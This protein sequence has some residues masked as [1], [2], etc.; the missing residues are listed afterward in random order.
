MT[1]LYLQ[2][3][4]GPD[5]LLLSV[6]VQPE[7]TVRKGFYERKPSILLYLRKWDI[8]LVLLL[9]YA[10]LEVN[11]KARAFKPHVPLKCAIYN[12]LKFAIYQII[13]F[14]YSAESMVII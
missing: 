9:Y 14:L 10:W 5:T 13:I 2:W 3:L 1:E 8:F 7:R 4:L 11:T 6:S 12:S